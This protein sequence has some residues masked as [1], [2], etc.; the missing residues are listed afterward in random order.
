M[1]RIGAIYELLKH[2]LFSDSLWYVF[3]TFLN[4][5][6]IF[7]LLP[8]FTAHFSEED[9]GMIGLIGALYGIVSVYIGLRPSLFVL[10]NWSKR[11]EDEMAEVIGNSVYLT[12][13]TGFPVLVCLWVLAYY[14]I[15]F[16]TYE[17]VLIIGL[18]GLLNIPFE[19]AS[20]WFQ[21]NRKPKSYALLQMLK[22]VMSA[23]G[24]LLLVIGFD[25]G[26]RGKF[27]SDIIAFFVLSAFALLLLKSNGVLVMRFRTAVIK[28]LFC[29]LFPLSFHVIGL[30]LINGGDRFLIE[31]FMNVNS[32]GVY[33]V[34]CMV[35]ALVGMVHDSLLK[36]WNPEFYRLMAMGT[37]K[38]KQ[39]IVKFVYVYMAFSLALFLLFL[40]VA[41][42]VFSLMVDQKFI[43]AMNLS[44]L[45]AG[46][47]TIES[48]RKVFIA[49]YYS[50]GK[51]TLIALITSVG[52]VVNLVLNWI[53]IP[54]YG[55]FGAAVAT[56]L[57]NL[58][59]V[60]VTLALLGRVEKMPW[61]LRVA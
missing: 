18:L 58:I 37:N 4:K 19:M 26:W 27:Y 31:H 53:L 47:L 6:L 1:P 21:L 54:D 7:L 9:Y 23:G 34:A 14:Q 59:T 61:G 15:I 38:V 20:V 30:T 56:V 44:I 46:G 8:I 3:S 11:G 36:V 33:T 10:V 5:G 24:A 32:V 25:A 40:M 42:W 17:V 28:E 48:Y 51:T 12:L 45:V 22:T 41:P 60:A 2:R 16:V 35:G 50:Q 52:V 57:S 39:K 13:L 49:F 29:Y 43:G 55:L